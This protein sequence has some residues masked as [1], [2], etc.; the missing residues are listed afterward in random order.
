MTKGR[1]ILI[2]TL[3]VIIMIFVVIYQRTTG[4]TYPDKGK[5]EIHGQ[6]INYSLPRSNDGSSTVKVHINDD[7]EQLTGLV[8]FRRYKSHDEWS[9]I[10]LIRNNKELFFI[11]PNQPAAGKVMYHI[12]LTKEGKSYIPLTEE[13]IILRF[14]DP[15]P[16]WVLVFHLI[17]IFAT[18]LLSNRAG[19]EALFKGDKVRLYSWLTVAAL[20]LGGFIFGPLMQKYAFGEYWTGVP[21]GYDLTD[22]KTLVAF[23]FWIIAIFFMYWK[24][25]K[26]YWQVLAASLLIIVYLIPHSLLGSE[27][28][29]T[30][31]EPKIQNESST[32]D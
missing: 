16:D 28:D 21:F 18:I 26:K 30:K 10:D 15:V 2:W 3:S 1:T 12:Y 5:N 31:T 17:F 13:P 23:I 7:S 24:P 29:Y 6:L 22:N 27:I 32:G 20:I 9:K 11:I 8:N 14:R 19:L 4:P 25:E